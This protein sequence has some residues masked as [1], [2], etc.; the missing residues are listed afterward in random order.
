MLSLRNNLV[1]VIKQFAIAGQ[2]KVVM[3]NLC[4]GLTY[5]IMHTHH[6]WAN[7]IEELIVVLNGSA[8]EAQTL[9]RITHFIA[10]ECEDESIVIEETLREH[11]FDFLDSITPTIF[12]R[13]HTYWAGQLM[14]QQIPSENAPKLANGIMSSFYQW[15]RLKLP[16]TV[17]G[18]L[19]SFNRSVLELVFS[20]MS[21]PSSG[22]QST[23]NATDCIIQLLKVTKKISHTES[24][25]LN[26]FLLSKVSILSSQVDQVI[27][28]GDLQVG[29]LFQELFLEIGRSHMKDVVESDSADHTILSILLRLMMM[30]YDPD[31]SIVQE[32]IKARHQTSFWKEFIEYFGHFGSEAYK[33][34]LLKKFEGDLLRLLDQILCMFEISPDED[35][36]QFNYVHSEDEMFDDFFK[37]KRDLGSIV[38]ETAKLIGVE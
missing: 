6:L 8:V 12:E 27:S 14:S 35:F 15:M 30:G 21:S 26:N 24:A 33:L 17:F 32:R 1:T 23:E 7:M 36:E 18:Q 20:E 13:V 31:P 19:V 22:L 29:E 2:Q 16:S 34:E 10:S 3:D 28:K 25:E 5:I 4:L 38:R 37:D 9:L 11:F